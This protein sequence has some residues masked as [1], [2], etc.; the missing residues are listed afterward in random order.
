MN[1]T[2]GTTLGMEAKLCVLGYREKSSEGVSTTIVVIRCLFQARK[3]IVQRWQ[4]RRPPSVSEWTHTINEIIWKEK[5]VYTKRG[6]LREFEK[7]W[8]PWLDKMGYPL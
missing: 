3:L 1:K 4:L 5:V 8:R 2:Y 7:M 6:N